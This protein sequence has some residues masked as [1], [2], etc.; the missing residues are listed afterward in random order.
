MCRVFG[1]LVL[2]PFVE[3]PRS[4]GGIEAQQV[5]EN[6]ADNNLKRA[7]S[8]LGMMVG[9]SRSVEHLCHTRSKEL[10]LV[11]A[12]DIPNMDDRC[13]KNYS[14]LISFAEM[15]SIHILFNNYIP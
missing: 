6:E 13:R 11:I 1:R 7:S 10:Q 2:I 5:A 15:V 12:R 4:P 14:L 3:C 9:L 8:A